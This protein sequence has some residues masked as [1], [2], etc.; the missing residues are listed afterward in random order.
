MDLRDAILTRRSIRRFT[1]DPVS[2]DTIKELVAQAL[3][4]PSWGNTQPWE[5]LA[6]T[7]DALQRLKDENVKA[8]AAGKELNPDVE[9]PQ[10]W[11]AL[12]KARYRDVGISVFKSLGIERNDLEKRADYYKEMASFF[13]SQALLLITF[14]KSLSLPYSMLDVGLFLQ[15]FCLLAH[16]SGLGTCIL[17][18]SVHF[19]DILRDICNIGDSK[20]IVIGVA[21]GK[22]DKDDAANNFQRKRD[23][24]D[25]FLKIIS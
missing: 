24:V 20:R 6:V 8:F 25:M 21:L 4:S 9:M 19:P 3:W 5:F 23:N 11:P 12:Q 2:K 18:V 15:S 17:A 16:N 22:P 7:G 10:S 13:N 1:N 14:D